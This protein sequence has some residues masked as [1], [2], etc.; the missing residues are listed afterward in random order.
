MNKEEYSNVTLSA[1]GEGLN[2]QRHLETVIKK[3]VELF[4]E[5]A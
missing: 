5:W 2:N 4:P 1:G 3:G